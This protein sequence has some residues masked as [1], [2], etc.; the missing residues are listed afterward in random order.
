MLSGECKVKS[1]VFF[2]GHWEHWVIEPHY[3]TFEV[4]E[5]H[6]KLIVWMKIS[7]LGRSCSKDLTVV[8]FL[9]VFYQMVVFVF[10][11][12]TNNFLLE[13]WKSLTK[14]LF[15]FYVKLWSRCNIVLN[16]CND[17][18]T[19]F[20][21]FLFVRIS[22]AVEKCCLVSV[23]SQKSMV[24]QK[25][26]KKLSLRSKWLPVIMPCNLMSC[27]GDFAV[28]LFEVVRYLIFLLFQILIRKKVWFLWVVQYLWWLKK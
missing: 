19:K 13:R 11:S 12:L 15:S 1:V 14:C 5:S 16:D 24:N 9:S 27:G 6:P 20:V 28:D 18:I 26:Q 7:L 17:L 4:L 23:F 25:L 2:G 3:L 21:S 10:I 22:A 8:D